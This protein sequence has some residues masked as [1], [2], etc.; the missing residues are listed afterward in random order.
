MTSFERDILTELD[1]K[2]DRVLAV[3]EGS[4]ARSGLV[5]RVE[6]LERTSIKSAAVKTFVTVFAA[7]LS[8]LAAAYGTI[9]WR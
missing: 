2:M 5:E 4:S 8:A 3:L 7:L 1:A 9:H 6:I